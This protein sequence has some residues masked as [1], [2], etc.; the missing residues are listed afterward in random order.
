[1]TVR[2]SRISSACVCKLGVF[3]PNLKMIVVYNFIKKKNLNAI[4][5]TNPE[6]FC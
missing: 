2:N 3:I 1:M 4:Y 6:H 5:K